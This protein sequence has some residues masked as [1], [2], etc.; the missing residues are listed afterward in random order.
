MALMFECLSSLMAGNPLL[1]PALEG[2]PGARTHHQ[3]SIV[4][5]INI[6]AFTDVAAYK[7]HVD[8]VVDRLKALPTV[9]GCAEVFVP[10][11]PEYRTHDTRK[12][13]GI[14]LPDGTVRNLRGVAE[15]F[16]VPMPPE[17]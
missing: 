16:K 15:R 8:G 6:A 1:E 2:V 7:A 13:N 4:A 12:K 10:G 17:L 9:E 5:A 3:N 14:P 11:E